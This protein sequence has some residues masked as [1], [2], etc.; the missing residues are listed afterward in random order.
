LKFNPAQHPHRRWNPLLG[1]WILVSP[2]RA[3]RPW[4]GKVEKLPVNRRPEY[5]PKCYLCPGNTRSS[6]ISND[7]YTSTFVFD[8]DF[9]ALLSDTVENKEQKSLNNLVRME[10]V[11]GIC[12][13][14]CFSPRHDLT[15]AEMSSDDIREVIRVWTEQ[16]RDL[17][18][19]DFIN[20]VTIF[21]NKGEIMGCSNPHPHG[22][23]WATETIPDTLRK[24]IDTQEI[25]LKENGSR[26]LSDYLAWELESD[27]RIID[28]NDHFVSLVP[29]WAVWPFEAMILPRRPVRN[30]TE[31]SD[32]EHVSWSELLLKLLIRYDNLFETPFPY[33]MGIHQEP[34]DGREHPS[35]Q[36]HQHFFPPLLRSA[37]IRKFQ[38]GYEMSGEPQRDITPE[39]AAERL[40]ALPE[41]HYAQ[42][43]I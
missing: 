15:M 13:V 27:E 35:F 33:S 3:T 9:S 7:N 34:A 5:D 2:H 39:Q 30:I 12:R 18:G 16:Y 10:G 1:E 31:L 37:T 26:M 36:M 21:E 22:Q 42:S 17:G 29:H 41:V 19:N 11:R 20:A 24:E 23:I 43:E 38:V 40:R 28:R 25:Y 8:N 6:G 4:S 14:I 32:E